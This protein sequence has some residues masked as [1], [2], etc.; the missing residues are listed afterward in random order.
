MKHMEL[1]IIAINL[2]MKLYNQAYQFFL[3][4]LG[5]TLIKTTYLL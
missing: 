1:S 2:R 5:T 4:T 3:D